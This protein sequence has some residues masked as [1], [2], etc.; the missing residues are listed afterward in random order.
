MQN[1]LQTIRAFATM[2]HDGQQRRYTPDP[3]IIHP[4]HVMEICSEHTTDSCILYAA[5]LHDVLEDTVVSFEWMQSFLESILEPSEA[6]RTL[7]I[8]VELTD[9]YIKARFPQW[10]R[11]K[12]KKKEAER[13]GQAS[14]AAQTVKYADIID[15]CNGITKNDPGF[16]PTYLRECHLLLN[17]MQS[18]QTSLYD[19]AKTTLKKEWAIL[20]NDKHLHP[21]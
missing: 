20:Q 4:E 8:V 6:E 12:R 21:T 3:Y 7:G 10:N 14:S 15:N 18:G 19:A 2:A 13:L 11:R 16:A 9:V 5:L 1:K 17:Y